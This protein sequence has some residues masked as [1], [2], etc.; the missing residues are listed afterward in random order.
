MRPKN[1]SFLLVALFSFVA[2][3][4]CATMA[5]L[6]PSGPELFLSEWTGMWRSLNG[7]SGEVALTVSPRPDGLFTLDVGLTNSRS[8]SW[9]TVARFKDGALVVDRPSL[10]MELR[11]YEGDRLEATY[12][13]SG[14]DRGSWSLVRKKK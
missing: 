10:Q 1:L 6:K 13:V 11:L 5:P 7:S 12:D 2:V 4:A 14:G 9:S 8:S 3:A